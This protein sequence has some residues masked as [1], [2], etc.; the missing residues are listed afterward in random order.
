[1]PRALRPIH[2]PPRRILAGRPSL[3]A[4]ASVLSLAI[5]T[6]LNPRITSPSASFVFS[7]FCRQSTLSS[8][9]LT[10]PVGITTPWATT[11]P[12][13]FSRW[14]GSRPEARGNKCSK[15]VSTQCQ[16]SRFDK[17]VSLYV[18]GLVS[19]TTD[20]LVALA[21]DNQISC[22]SLEVQHNVQ[23]TRQPVDATFRWRATNLSFSSLEPN[24]VGV[25]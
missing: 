12:R 20:L 14:H 16:C 22:S 9:L 1:M 4:L 8:G 15:E 18:Y 10:R 23:S 11:T 7:V 6:T 21:A 2:L 24:Q 13:S 25:Q 3:S 17:L 5:T 19:S